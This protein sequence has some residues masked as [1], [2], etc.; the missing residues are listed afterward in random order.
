MWSKFLIIFI[1]TF[2]I[3]NVNS[4]KVRKKDKK[5]LLQNQQ[6]D[7]QKD[8]QKDL[9]KDPQKD[10]QIQHNDTTIDFSKLVDLC[11]VQMT[12]YCTCK[13]DFYQGYN[14]KENRKYFITNCSNGGLNDTRIL[15]YTP[16]ETEIL[17]FTNNYI[18]TLPKYLFDDKSNYDRL[19]IIDLS[20]NQIENIKSNS[21]YKVKYLKK[22]ILNNNKLQLSSR[23]FQAK[24]FNN[25]ENLEELYLKNA[26]APVSKIPKTIG[27]MQTLN[28]M[29]QEAE[30]THLKI[31]NL[32]E[33]SIIS[34]P[35][36]FI[37]CSL[38]SLQKVYLAKNLIDDFKLNLTCT[39]KLRLIDL[40]ENQFTTLTN[41][42]FAYLESGK[43]IFHINLE[44]NGWRC[45]CKFI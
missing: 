32:E 14:L 33:N 16:E 43:T 25:F 44:N 11:P 21:F 38:P 18:E 12:R 26:L 34:F 35:T 31:L 40:T 24:M 15:K 13:R 4:Q 7:Q 8:A 27:F 6:T 23:N 42:S 19:M 37:F 36:P 30:L 22:L 3:I 17:I 10:L 9:Q 2:F 29:L 39:P 28:T 1:L 5:I 45:D 20:N 41:S